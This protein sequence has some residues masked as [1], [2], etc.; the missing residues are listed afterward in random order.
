MYWSNPN[1]IKTHNR[2]IYGFKLHISLMFY[3][4]ISGLILIYR[5]I[6]TL[7]DMTII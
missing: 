3:L 1:T 7:A 5:Y 6:D 4:Q 2:S